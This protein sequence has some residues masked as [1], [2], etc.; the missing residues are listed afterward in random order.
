MLLE[1]SPKG[2]CLEL[3][4]RVRQRRVNM[5]WFVHPVH[6]IEP[7]DRLRLEYSFPAVLSG[8]CTSALVYGLNSF[9][10]VVDADER[11]AQQNP[12]CNLSA[13]RCGWAAW[14]GQVYLH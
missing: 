8:S 2:A 14:C 4:L 10:S 13:D 11:N 9:A 5:S 3:Q 12:P 7:T 1:R 6:E